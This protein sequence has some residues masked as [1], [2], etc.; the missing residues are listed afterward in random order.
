MV[1]PIAPRMIIGITPINEIPCCDAKNPAVGNIARVGIGGIIVSIKA[2][3]KI[4]PTKLPY[5]QKMTLISHILCLKICCNP[6]K[7]IIRNIPKSTI[8]LQVSR[9]CN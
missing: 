2:A 9:S 7:L 6:P 1:A 8:E 5:E 3:K 4:V